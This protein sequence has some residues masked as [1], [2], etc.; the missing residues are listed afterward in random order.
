MGS[1]QQK[2][3]DVCAAKV[4]VESKEEDCKEE[5]SNDKCDVLDSVINLD[6]KNQDHHL[7]IVDD[8]SQSNHELSNEEP[9]S[10]I[11]EN[12]PEQVIETEESPKM[13]ENDESPLIV[14]DV[15]EKKEESLEPTISESQVKS[16]KK[17]RKSQIVPTSESIESAENVEEPSLIVTKDIDEKKEESLEP[18]I[19]ESQVKGKKKKRKSQIVPTSE[20]IESAENV[21]EPSLIVTK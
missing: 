20:S 14:Q 1:V 4:E 7:A 11:P 13:M 19:S 17:K 3:T 5:S 18:T 9:V 2:K 6:V 8:N 16:K 10:I 15:D 12:V 21:E